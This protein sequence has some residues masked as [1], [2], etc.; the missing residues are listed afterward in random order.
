MRGQRVLAAKDKLTAT[1]LQ[2]NAEAGEN[3]TDFALEIIR[4]V[5]Q[6][7]TPQAQ[8]GT[9]FH[10][11]GTAISR[12]GVN[13]EY[14]ISQEAMAHEVAHEAEAVEQTE[15]EGRPVPRSSAICSHGS[16]GSS[17]RHG[18]HVSRPPWSKPSPLSSAA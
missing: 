1:G 9:R 2:R 13:P 14:G 16:S 7:S 15:R 5:P 8:A 6:V 11:L 17:S 3:A 10:S 18:R 4:P 12:S